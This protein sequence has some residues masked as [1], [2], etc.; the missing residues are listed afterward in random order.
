VISKSIFRLYDIRGKVP[1]E[2][3]AK[4]ALKVGEA[5][6]KFFK[7][8]TLVLGFDARLTSPELYDRLKLGLL[9]N[10]N[11]SFLEAG[12]I[13]TPM[14]Y[15]LVNFKEAAG[16]VMVTASHNPK[17]F[18]GFKVVKKSAEPVSGHEILKFLE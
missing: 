13:T 18:N 14:L 3:D 6:G 8:G 11:L 4:G 12:L 9:K 1:Q 16:G 2:L 15:F 7:Y 10:K 5:L 17:N